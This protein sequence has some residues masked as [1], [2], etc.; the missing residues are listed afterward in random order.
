M[1]AL[2]VILA[3]QIVSAALAL[4]AIIYLIIRRAKKRK[5]EGFERRDN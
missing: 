3:I 1:E 4:I 2:K 5:E